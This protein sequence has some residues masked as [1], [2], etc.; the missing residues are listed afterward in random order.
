MI[1]LAGPNFGTWTSYSL[2]DFVFLHT[3][4]KAIKVFGTA[5]NIFHGTSLKVFAEKCVK[6]DVSKMATYE[7]IR[8]KH[9][10][11]YYLISMTYQ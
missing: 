9:N 2:A 6:V 4:E 1:P 8:S 5:P 10:L 3:D 7:V 11:E